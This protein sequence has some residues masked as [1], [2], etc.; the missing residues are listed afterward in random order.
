MYKHDLFDLQ[1]A[2]EAWLAP[3]G[4]QTRTTKSQITQC[5]KYYCY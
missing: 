1:Q 5:A 3:V 4:K 2:W